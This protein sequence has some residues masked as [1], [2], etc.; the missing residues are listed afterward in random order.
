MRVADISLSI[1]LV[2]A[3]KVESTISVNS[4]GKEVVQEPMQT[5]DEE[6]S[7]SIETDEELLI[8]LGSIPPS[9]FLMNMAFTLLAM[10]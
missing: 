7:D 8:Q 4:K 5:S 6:R 2:L 9:N 10:F 3:S 1:K